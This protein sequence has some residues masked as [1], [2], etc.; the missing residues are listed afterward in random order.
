M[1]SKQQQN[2]QQQQICH[3]QNMEI[4]NNNKNNSPYLHGSKDKS[5]DIFIESDEKMIKKQCESRTINSMDARGS[6]CDSNEITFEKSRVDSNKDIIIMEVTNDI[7]EKSHN[8]TVTTPP[9]GIKQIHESAINIEAVIRSDSEQ[10]ET[11]ENTTIIEAKG[12]STVQ[13]SGESIFIYISYYM[14]IVAVAFVPFCTKYQDNV[15]E[16]YF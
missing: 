10:I 14:F 13:T 16:L 9:I 2:H 4:N 1:D 12:E 8:E 11:M 6:Q 7:C 15:N 3:G 5:D